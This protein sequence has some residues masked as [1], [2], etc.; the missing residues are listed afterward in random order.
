MNT[1]RGNESGF[2]FTLKRVT[3]A[4]GAAHNPCLRYRCNNGNS[5]TLL[6][7]SETVVN[8]SVDLRVRGPRKTDTTEQAPFIPVN[9]RCQEKS[10]G[11]FQC[12]AA[13]RLSSTA[14]LCLM[15]VNRR[16]VVEYVAVSELRIV[17][18]S[19]IPSTS[20]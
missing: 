3:V 8:V 18:G 2:A 12:G 20:L 15:S 10:E 17:K 19:L 16:V 5:E 9:K 6:M 14:T 13:K 1:L 7:G 4:K 11:E